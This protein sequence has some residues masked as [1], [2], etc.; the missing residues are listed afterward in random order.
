MTST[1]S[2]VSRLVRCVL[3]CVFA[4]EVIGAF[5][6]AKMHG[7]AVTFFMDQMG[8]P[9]SIYYTIMAVISLTLLVGILTR[10]AALIGLGL[11]SGHLLLMPD[12]EPIGADILLKVVIVAFLVCVV[13]RLTRA[14]GPD[15][16]PCP[17][18]TPYSSGLR[19][20]IRAQG[21]GYPH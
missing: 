1:I 3:S 9:A 2:T 10:A 7:T 21:P 11:Y 15:E 4:L 18:L 14:A 5:A 16:T 13:A 8:P 12:A 6:T 17:P 19:R 20:D